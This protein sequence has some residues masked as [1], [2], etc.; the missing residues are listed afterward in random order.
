MLLD[1]LKYY[2]KFLAQAEND[3][4]LGQEIAKAHFKTADIAAKLGL[5]ADAL[6][7]YQTAEKLLKDLTSAKLATDDVQSQLATVHNNLGLL[8]AVRGDVP[9]ARAHY[10]AAIG[11]QQHL[12]DEHKTDPTFA[13]Q[14]AESEGNLGMLLDQIGDSP[15]AEKSLR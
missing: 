6:T 5:S 9:T 2:R 10:Q 13:G 4:Q 8:F 7:E 12:V 1:A 3:S 14:L 11:I 15:Q